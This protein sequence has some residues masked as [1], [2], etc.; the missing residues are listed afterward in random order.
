M[1]GVYL[2]ILLLSSALIAQKANSDSIKN[3]VALN[4][5]I[6]FT[7]TLKSSDGQPRLGTVGLT[8]RL[9]ASEEG[10]DPLWSESQTVQ[11]DDQGRYSV[12][13]GATQKDGLPLEVFGAGR[14]QWLGVEVQGESEQSRVVLLAV[15]Y[16][17]KAADADTVGGRPVSSFVLQ[18][19]VAK[20]VE[21]YGTSVVLVGQDA[22]SG[23]GGNA[24]ANKSVL[25]GGG[26]RALISGKGIGP[27]NYSETGTN[28]LFGDS[29]GNGSAASGTNNSY[30]GYYAG[31]AN[32]SADGGYSN[33]SFFGYNAGL[34]TLAGN[35]SFFGSG[36]GLSNHYGSGNAFFGYNAGYANTTASYNSFF[37]YLA[38]SSNTIGDSNSFFGSGAGQSNVN[39]S[40]NAFF[41]YNAGYS[42]YSGGSNSFFG[43]GAGYSNVSGGNSF[44]GY[45]AGN[46]N[47]GG[48]S[49]SFV[50]R[51]AGY[52]NSMG[53]KNSFVGDSAGYSNTRGNEN[54]FFG[55]D[56][57]YSNTSGSYNSYFGSNAGRS[58]SSFTSNNSF[59]GYGAGYSNTGDDNSFFGSN[60]GRS[61]LSA[62]RNSFTGS[63]A[64]YSNSM[65]TD[66]AFFG[67]NAGYSNTSGDSNSYFGSNAGKSSASFTSGNSFYGYSAGYSNTGS[68]NSFFGRNAGYSNTTGQDNSFFGTSAGYTNTD[69]GGN[70]FF[71]SAA[72]QLNASGYYN[73]FFGYL[74]G[75]QNSGG[76]LNAFFGMNA[77]SHNTN[78]SANSVFGPDSGQQNTTGSENTFVGNEAGMSNT[79]ESKN[80]FI[81]ASSDGAAGITNATAIGYRAKVTQSNSLVLGG[82]NGVNGATAD[83]NV[84]MGTTSP[85][86]RLH[87]YHTGTYPRIYI[88]GD[89][90][91]YPG[92]QL[93]FDSAGS[94]V[95]LMRAVEQDTNGTAL[96]FYTRNNT[97]NMIQGM[98]IDDVGNV[99]IGTATP[100]ERLQVAGN[101]KVSGA[102]LYGAPEME[103]PDF[104]FESN[105]D[106]MPIR[107]L[108]RF[109][110][111]EKHLP[112]VPKASE[113]REKGLNLSEFQMKLLEKIEELTLYTVQQAKVIGQKDAE[114][115]GLNARLAALEQAVERLTK[116]EH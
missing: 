4:R 92:F 70:T 23:S 55:Y 39:G 5:V 34:S 67:Y 90:G 75:N 68:N 38:G 87:I 24:T 113:I 21:K 43:V 107:E 112:N 33:N 3:E 77:G 48:Y 111:R 99:G 72:G 52:S 31:Y 115:T 83:T 12:L 94:R 47:T 66:N 42:N 26:L 27:F 46:G 73:S 103:L 15:P 41:G 79:V 101:L 60:A 18:E 10:G 25:A 95:A 13:L 11:T 93:G 62:T 7:G 20:V 17:L 74:A 61:N 45:N 50:G 53:F 58:S 57:G 97:A 32:G 88:Q 102:I 71:G 59:Y 84:G 91:K 30:F 2:V 105:Y 116:P 86:Y 64:G 40:G 63:G 104:V 78:G 89:S 114:I 14:A 98:I 51:S 29:A 85:N 28:T 100:T 81:G 1:V 35:N 69:S 56:A 22:V 19:D 76:I 80:S 6:A 109:I 8:F 49:N 106:L 110:A 36:A 44:F 54:A 108:E 9:Y 65:G 16:A 96:Q 37:G 82:I